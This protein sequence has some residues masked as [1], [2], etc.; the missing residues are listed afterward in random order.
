MQCRPQ[1]EQWCFWKSWK[2]YNNLLIIRG[3]LRYFH[4]L[5]NRVYLET[6]LHITYVLN[7]CTTSACHDFSDFL[8]LTIPVR[9]KIA[10]GTVIN[11]HHRSGQISDIWKTVNS[12][13]LYLKRSA[14]YQNYMHKMC[15]YLKLMKL[16]IHT[17]T[18]LYLPR[19]AHRPSS[20]DILQISCYT[21]FWPKVSKEKNN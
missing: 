5:L 15:I 11:L 14:I 2:I 9:Y 12:L 1:P 3:N 19:L 21:D 4:I 18:K 13:C 6:A 16:K 8:G 10:L 20:L 17:R 7:I